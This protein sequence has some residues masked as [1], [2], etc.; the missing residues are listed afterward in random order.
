MSRQ[1][2]LQ[3]QLQRYFMAQMFLTRIPVPRQADWSDQQLAAST[4]YFPMVGIL[5]GGLAS[6]GWLVGYWGWSAPLAAMLAVTVA[7]L[8]TGAF[9]EDGLADS[10]DGIG[11]AFAIEKKLAIMRDSRIGT[12]GSIALILVTLSKVAAITL[13]TPA[14]AIPVLIGA[15]TIARWTSL[16]LIYNNIYVREHGTGKPFASAVTVKTVLAGSVFTALVAT[17]CFGLN[18]LAIIAFVIVSTLCAQWYL[19]VKLGGI[20]G[21]ALGAVNSLTELLVYLLATSHWLTP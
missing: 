20:T 13:L 7:V 17:L 3:Q 1:T 6:L 8:A 2:F 21:D 11:G 5:V 12:Y 14:N 10:A 16:P 4:V 15:H 9:H 18:A 19:R